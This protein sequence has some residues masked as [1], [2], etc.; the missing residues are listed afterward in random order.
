[1]SRHEV[2]ETTFGD[3]K[4]VEN[5]ECLVAGTCG[6]QSFIDLF[7]QAISVIR[8]DGCQ[9]VHDT[10]SRLDAPLVPLALGY[11]RP[12]PGQ[13]PELG[14]RQLRLIEEL[15]DLALL[16][17]GFRGGNPLHAARRVDGAPS[18]D[19]PPE[20][21]VRNDLAV[22]QGS[23]G[24]RTRILPSGKDPPLDAVAVVGDPRRQ[25][26][27]VLHQL[28]RYRAKEVRRYIYS[29]HQHRPKPQE[30]NRRES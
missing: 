24:D 8:Y 7:V 21:V 26:H 23:L 15:H 18:L 10:G 6:L 9:E 5:V 13:R 22:R 20:S 27:R 4:R 14:L 2:E 19:Q 29:L 16:D 28:Q 30:L 25:R 3:R 17:G 12:Q 11:D 1:M